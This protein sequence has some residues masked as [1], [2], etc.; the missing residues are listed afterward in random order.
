VRGTRP[1]QRPTTEARGAA[2]HKTLCPERAPQE[3]AALR[4]IPPERHGLVRA[5]A[6]GPKRSTC[7]NGAPLSGVARVPRS[8][9]W[10]EKSRDPARAVPPPPCTARRRAPARARP[11]PQPDV[12]GAVPGPVQARGRWSGG[13]TPPLQTRKRPC[14]S[15]Q[16]PLPAY[17]RQSRAQPAPGL[18]GWAPARAT[19]VPPSGSSRPPPE[20]ATP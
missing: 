7:D 5:R 13:G 3:R 20:P 4:R 10:S 15:S 8:G 19:E 14:P 2:G 18:P 17:R 6:R 12:A 16:L 9:E 1:S 11:G